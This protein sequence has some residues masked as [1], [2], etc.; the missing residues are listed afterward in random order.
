M[1]RQMQNPFSVTTS[2]VV[3][4]RWCPCLEDEWTD[5]RT[6]NRRCQHCGKYTRIRTL[7]EVI[8]RIGDRHFREVDMN[9]VKAL[10]W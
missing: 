2:N 4:G 9:T 1:T 3:V 6:M 5:V 10:G 7:V 8:D